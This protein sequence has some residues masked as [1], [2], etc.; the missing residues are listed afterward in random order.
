[1]S[2]IRKVTLFTLLASLVLVPVTAQV[3]TTGNGAPSGSHFNLNLIGFPKDTST[4]SSH[5]G[6]NVIFV[7]L[8]G[9]GEICLMA[10]S[11][12]AVI[13]NVAT[14]SCSLTPTPTGAIFELPNPAITSYTVWVRAL[15]K[16]GGNGALSTCAI[17]PTTGDTICSTQQVLVFRTHG[18]QTFADV[19]SQLTSVCGTAVLTLTGQNCV[20]IFDPALQGFFWQYDNNG[21]KLL[22]LRFYPRL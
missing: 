16:P 5:L 11:T 6:G 22:Q 12:F 18:R 4:L 14:N 7:P 17:D 3:L 13:S 1:M 2:P 21:V 10:G 9:R 20:N 8:N 15:G 19:T